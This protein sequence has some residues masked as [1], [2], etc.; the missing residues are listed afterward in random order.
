MKSVVKFLR[1][2]QT[3]AE[4]ALSDLDLP[5]FEGPG[6]RDG[7]GRPDAVL[8][9]LA[10]R[11]LGILQGRE[12]KLRMMRS[13]ARDGRSWVP[14][15]FVELLSDPSDE[16]RDAATRELTEREDYPL[17]L[18]YARLLRPPWYVR[19]AV[20]RVLESKRR[21]E[22]IR[23]IREI[24][25]DPNV[26]VKRSA[27]RALGAIGGPEAR[28]LLVRLTRDDN[29]YVRAAAVEALE[30]IVELKFS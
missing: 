19:S 13:M 2:R 17:E 3:A 20:L 7:N 11:R 12:K 10:L 29:P 23:P 26:D 8:V 4:N 9:E 1:R 18:L 5:P 6:G 15:V 21:P 27:A 30:K 16:I 28:R 25:D 22:S 24:V 14:L